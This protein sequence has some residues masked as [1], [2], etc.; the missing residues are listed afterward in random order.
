MSVQQK[1]LDTPAFF[2]DTIR[3]SMITFTNEAGRFSYRVAGIAIY[4]QHVL[5]QRAEDNSFWF[6]PGGRVELHEPAATSLQ[7]EMQEELGVDAQIHRLLWV[8]ENFYMW[9]T[10]ASHE[11]AFYFLMD[12]PPAFVEQSRGTPF[13]CQ[14][15]SITFVFEWLPVHSLATATLYPTFLR[16]KLLTLPDTIEHVV[17]T[18]EE[19]AVMLSDLYRRNASRRASS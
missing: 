7:R 14:D 3:M 1:H 2:L 10:Y 19:S 4:D 15:Q 16:H 8:V 17:H 9:R 12:L 18:D 6:P 13:I 5:L 11:I